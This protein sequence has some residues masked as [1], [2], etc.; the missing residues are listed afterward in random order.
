MATIVEFVGGFRDGGRF[1]TESEDPS[2][3]SWATGFLVM[4]N[5]DAIGS[6]FKGASDAAID[7]TQSGEQTSAKTHKYEVVERFQSGP[8]TIVRFKYIEPGS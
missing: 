1:S 8:N 7:R 6:W 3:A 4:A 5:N 2:E